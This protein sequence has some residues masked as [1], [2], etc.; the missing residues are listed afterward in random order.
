MRDGGNDCCTKR[1]HPLHL[2]I[3]I[4]DGEGNIG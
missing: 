1:N 3:T 4:G 2:S